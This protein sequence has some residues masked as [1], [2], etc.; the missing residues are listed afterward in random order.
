MKLIN[1]I[2]STFALT[3]HT[4]PDL[5]EVLGSLTPPEVQNTPT[6]AQGHPGARLS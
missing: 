4:R 1:D 5:G 3:G 2:C 6:H